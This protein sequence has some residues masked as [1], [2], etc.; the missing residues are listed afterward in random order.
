VTVGRWWPGAGGVVLNVVMT[1]MLVDWFAGNGGVDGHGDLH[2]LL[3]GRHR[4]GSGGAAAGSAAGGLQAAQIVVLA[5]IAAG[6]V[7]FRGG[8]SPAR[9][10]S[11]RG[12]RR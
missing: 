1:K 6:L 8:L 3:A 4:A 10:R 5:V 9:G 2:Q 11:V 7:L 12:R